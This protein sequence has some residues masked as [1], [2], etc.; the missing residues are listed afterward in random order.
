[1]R[2]LI[3]SIVLVAVLV[4]LIVTRPPATSTWTTAARD[5]LEP[6]SDPEPS[7]RELLGTHRM[8]FADPGADV[9][10]RWFPLRSALAVRAFP[11]PI[12]ESRAVLGDSFLLWVAHPLIDAWRRGFHLASVG[13]GN[14]V[15]STSVERHPE[16][17]ADYRVQLVASELE[18]LQ[19]CGIPGRSPGEPLRSWL[20]HVPFVETTAAAS[21]SL[22]RYEVIVECEGRRRSEVQVYF[23][24]ER[25]IVGG[26]FGLDEQ[27][28]GERWKRF[29]EVVPDELLQVWAIPVAVGVAREEVVEREAFERVRDA[30]LEAPVDDPNPSDNVCSGTLDAHVRTLMEPAGVH[31]VVAGFTYVHQW[32]SLALG[33]A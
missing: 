27:A 7:W 29:V 5:E 8:P 3:E 25:R 18:P 21:R 28:R 26:R 30:W 23:V 20:E 32:L 11:N 10:S 19:W 14:E 4:L 6:V 13:E 33:G 31:G 12:A 9:T 24:F 1:M 16:D 17:Y 2:G 22:H 15:R